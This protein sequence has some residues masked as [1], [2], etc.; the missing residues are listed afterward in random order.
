M[1]SEARPGGYAMGSS[2][3]R[4]VRDRVAS[5][6]AYTTSVVDLYLLSLFLGKLRGTVDRQSMRER[7]IPGAIADLVGVCWITR[8]VREL[9][10]STS[11]G[12]FLIPGAWHQLPHSSRGRAQTQG[13]QLHPR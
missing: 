1:S 13:N 11:N 2:T 12:K 4:R 3:C 7:P 10:E 6:K 8:T 9:A 5:T